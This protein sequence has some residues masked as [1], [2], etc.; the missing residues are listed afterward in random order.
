MRK[1]DFFRRLR[2]FS[3]SFDF[4]LLLFASKTST[5]KK[6]EQIER[7]N[8][9][10]VQQQSYT[11]FTSSRHKHFILGHMQVYIRLFCAPYYA[12]LIF[13]LIQVSRW[14]FDSTQCCIPIRVFLFFFSFGCSL[15][16]AYCTNCCVSVLLWMIV[17]V[18]W[19]GQ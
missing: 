13:L 16:T 15:S 12:S 18:V 17:H 6:N 10:C 7:K 2:F 9:N 14:P 3:S 4:F 5:H 1:L 19:G 11:T 8:L